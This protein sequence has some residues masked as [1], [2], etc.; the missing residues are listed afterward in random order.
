MAGSSGCRACGGSVSGSDRHDQ[1]SAASAKAN[2][3]QK[4]DRQPKA[5]SSAPPI[6]GAIA[7]ATP[8][9]SVTCDITFC[10]SAPWKRSRMIARPA[11]IGAPAHSPCSARA[12]HSDSTLP[13][14]AQASVAMANTVI[15]TS[16]TGRRPNASESAPCHS[17][18]KA[19]ASR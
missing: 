9:I 17:S 18:M 15:A 4:M 8:K 3:N 10:A 14:I 11:T 1:A 2:T 13:A 19:K 6:T 12:S 16:T 7:G 5:P